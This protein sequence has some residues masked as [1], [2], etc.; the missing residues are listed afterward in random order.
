M[1][2]SQLLESVHQAAD[3][4]SEAADSAAAS[5][6]DRSLGASLEAHPLLATIVGLAVLGGA[7]WL[8]LVA[9]RRYV[10]RLISH[11]TKRNSLWWDDLLFDEL[12]LKRLSWIV[13]ALVAYQGIAF[14]PYLPEAL[15]GLVR[16]IAL[17]SLALFG[18]RAFAALLTAVNEIY[19]RFPISKERPIKGLLQ[20]V[21]IVA[22]VFG[23]ILM[24]AALM[25]ES[26]L[27]FLSGLGAMT[28]I[29][30]LVF[31]DSILS[32]VAGYQV[33]RNGSIRLGDWIEMPQFNAD[34]AV[35]DIALNSVTVRNWD[36]TFTVIPAHRFLEHSFK[37]WRGMQQ[38]GGRRIKRS[39][40]IDVS[41][42]RF[43]TPEEVDHFERFRLLRDYI[44]QK[45]EELE[46]HNRL[47]ATDPSIPVNV[48]RLTNIGTLRAYIERYLRQ[49]P[50]IHQGM[51]LMVRQLQPTEQGLPLEIYCF[52]NDTRWV[53]YESIQS[54]IFD[55]ILAAVPHFGLRL[56]QNPTGSDFSR[57]LA[58]ERLAENRPAGELPASLTPAAK[59]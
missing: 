36:Q 30:M 9:V 17:A 8:G 34:G 43:L 42:I 40:L 6:V 52:T 23:G 3:S 1:I 55:H 19:N 58:S 47:H 26:P 41:S 29:I 15:A 18:V 49:H 4:L 46:E 59:T 11:L 56:F 57:A 50:G 7:A 13:P 38:A 24:I 48:R 37:N 2:V 22:H 28:A 51:T 21:N 20:V 33:T 5:I 12:V 32:L 27:L 45:K 16:R 53:N 35:V 54:D 39:I 44:R 14:V 10:L 25:D 31:R